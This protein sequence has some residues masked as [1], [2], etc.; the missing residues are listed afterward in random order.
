VIDFRYHLVSIVS[1]F[2][3]LA[4][5]IVL[6]AGPLKEDIGNTL[7]SEVNRLRDDKAALRTEL[8]AASKGASARDEFTAAGNRTLLAGRL[9]DA[10]LTLV[11]L[12]GADAEVVKSTTETL[13]AAGAKIGSTVTVLEA[14]TDPEKATFRN[15]LGQQLAPSVQVPLDQ[16]GSA[17]LDSVLA[18][19]LLTKA[20]NSPEGAA[21]ALEGM[22]TG[23]LIRYTPDEAVPAT[24]AVVV[25]G[26]VTGDE[27]AARDATA[28]A[29]AELAA[30]LDEAGSGAVLAEAMPD[31]SATSQSSVVAAARGDGETAKALSTVDDADLPMGQASIV[32]ALLEQFAGKAGQYGLQNDAAAAFPQLATK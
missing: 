23:E 11:V 18:R 9:Q 14:W 15:T 1:I 17:V 19:A 21:T 28:S 31:P 4:V 32:F 6:G 12:P 26:P 8:D 27:E 25:A 30:A 7:T 10:T 2:L 16:S 13:T 20:G 3:A 24:G 22:R 5:G 29:L